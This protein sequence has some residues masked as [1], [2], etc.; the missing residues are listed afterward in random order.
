M[1]VYGPN[2][3][4][5]DGKDKGETFQNVAS[6]EENFVSFDHPLNLNFKCRSV[7]G[8]P[9]LMLEVWG[10]DS[11]NRN[12]LIGYSCNFIPFLNGNISLKCYTWRPEN[13]VLKSFFLGITKEF[14]S[15]SIISSNEEKFQLNTVSTGYVTVELDIII[16]DF[17]LHGI[18]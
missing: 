10:T 11:D 9:K 7:K 15:K 4:L 8:W 5:I 12:S 16:K 14:E 13:S 2:F 1:F 3:T 18:E 17:E 6:N